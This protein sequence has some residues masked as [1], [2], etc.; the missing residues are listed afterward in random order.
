MAQSSRY[1]LVTLALQSWLRSAA[2]TESGPAEAA[3]K[4]TQPFFDT[5]SLQLQP[6]YTDIHDGGND[7]QLLVRLFVV[8]HSLL[9]PGVKTLDIYTLARLEMYGESLNTPANPNVVGLQDWNALF[10]AIK[11]FRWGAQV[12]LGAYAVIPTATNAALD[13]QELQ[14]GPALGAIITRVRH[15]QI[16]ILAEF[17]FSVAGTTPDLAHSQVQPILVYHLPKAFFL[18]SD[19]IAQFDFHKSPHATV[20]VNIHFGRGITSHLVISA[21]V[22]GVTTGSGFANVTTK[23]NLNYLAW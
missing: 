15:L 9:I 18:K 10:L 21:I 22:E 13:T 14:L 20:P 23:L 2:A 3:E 7:T 19:G 12:A 4:A 17:Y 11:P 6:A 5:N 1:L 8:Y 16:G